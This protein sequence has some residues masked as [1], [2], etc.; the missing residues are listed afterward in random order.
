MQRQF[1]T[2]QVEVRFSVNGQE[3]QAQVPGQMTLLRFLRDQM[4]LMGAKDGC[5]T[6]HCGTCT[7]IV[8]DKA[9]RACLVKMT[10][11]DGARVETIEGLA[12]GSM[13]HP[14]QQA[15]IEKGA[16]QCGFCTPGMIMTAKALLD[17]NSHP[18]LS[19]IKKALTQNHNL[20][21]CTGYIKIFEAIELAAERMADGRSQSHETP[22]QDPTAG[23]SLVDEIAID[24]VTGKNVFGDDIV[25]ERMLHGKILWSA[26]P[27][28][29]ILN[30]D[31]REAE[32]MDGVVAVITAKDIPGKNQAGVVVRDQPAIAAD[33]THYIGDS[34]A[35][36]FAES[37]ETAKAAV[38]KIRVEYE[39]LPGVFSPEEAAK[40]DA[41]KVHETGNLLHHAEIIRGDVGKAFEDCAVI[42]EETYTTPFI[43]HAFLEPEAGVAYLD[44][45]GG[46]VLKIG[47][48]T[49]FDDRTQLT[50]ILAMPED[51]IRV[52]QIPPGGAFGAKEDMIL[53]QYLAL[54]AL[55]ARRPVKMVL[56]REESL[57]VHVKRHPAQMHF[58]TGA[59][60]AG[61]VLAL[62][63]DISLDTGAYASLGIDVLENTVVFAAGPYYVPNLKIR[64]KS[65]YTNN[66]LAG[67][68]RG[69]GV[70]Q[71]AFALEQQM[72]AMARAL[73]MDPFEFRLLNALE[74]GLPT[75]TDHV[76]EEG[77]VSIKQTIQA[78]RQAFEAIHLPGSDGKKIGVGVAS[79]VKNIGF[80][81]AIPE[82]AGAVVELDACGNALVRASQHEYG[83][84][85]RMG[86]I[87]L[88][89]NE[90][91][92]PVER[93]DVL[94]PDT[95]TTPPTGPTTASRQT[96]LS[97]NAVVMACQALKNDLF[98]HAAE[99]LGVEPE[100]LRFQGDQIVD[101][102]S[103]KAL[104]LKELGERFVTARRYVPPKTD[105]MLAVGEVSRFGGS[106]FRS[107]VTHFCYA[108]NTQVA[109]VEA[110]PNTGEVKVLSIISAN[111]VGKILNRQAIEGQIHGGVVMGMG[112]ALSEQFVVDQ[113]INL[114]DTL[115]K[116][117]I[118][119]ADQAP[120]II[121]SIVE[122]P[123]PFGPEG[124]KG[125]AEAPSLATAPAIVNAIYDALGVRVTSLPAYKK[126]VLRALQ[127]HN[128]LH[129]VRKP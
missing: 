112:Y 19:E 59:D 87:K 121:C 127:N 3:I 68:M 108:Y 54:G 51:K 105:G 82:D 12:K 96:F 74:V 9:I 35:A 91:G 76:L 43:E 49:A 34:L 25:M 114:T 111:D 22:T 122:V 60:R 66:V 79:A 100:R 5:S 113:G 94:T 124:A 88:A 23:N 10:K 27:H 77:V 56:T 48:Q 109:V 4:G 61:H 78:A 41:P 52:I 93:I 63:A 15:F 36:V 72:D 17:S 58:K 85:A 126:E 92:I 110:D 30:I 118:P 38:E 70:N 21:R 106:D 26:Y 102:Q 50:E 107:R 99:V 83:Q 55:K 33:E 13:L 84:G 104:D 86:L 117:H 46:V 8:D 115:Y 24:M 69:F 65:W 103:D 116:C 18:T 11:I 62:E 89:S 28:A 119:T 1:D 97:G 53:Q 6:G 129:Y 47:T 40:P 125:F 16:V 73:S 64:G 120:E 128:E 37:I 45:D 20:C 71:V 39:V 98:G 32:A 14:I 2:T 57:R 31:T 75:A 90:L 29:H 101:T 44:E 95:R 81:H 7:V 80:G 123:H 67:A 42:V